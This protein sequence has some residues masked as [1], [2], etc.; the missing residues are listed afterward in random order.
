MARATYDDATKAAVM[1]NTITNIS[2]LRPD[3]SNA[4]K[5]TERGRYM[6]EA[7][8]REA[9]AGRSI[10]VDR[11][12]RIIAGNKTLDAWAEIGGEIEVVRTDGKRLVVVQR[13]DL[14]LADADS[15]A[16]RLAY[17][18]NR[19]G[20][21]GL[22]W[23]AEQILADVNAG[24]PLDDMFFKD[25]LDALLADVLPEPDPGEDPGP[26]VDRAEE[27]RQEWGVEPGQMW[28]L[29]EHRLICGDCTDPA[30]VE[31]VMGGEKAGAVVTDPPYGMNY[32]SDAGGKVANDRL[33]D[34]RRLLEGLPALFWST[35]AQRIAVWTRWDIWREI[36]DAFERLYPPCAMVV[37]S[38]ENHAQGNTNHFG[39]S[40]ELCYTSAPSNWVM[41]VDGIRPLNVVT[42]QVTGG[43]MD[44]GE[45]YH[46]TQKPIK[47]M[48]HLLQAMTA[49]A[50]N[51]FDPFS[52]SGTT[53]IACE[54]LGRK[55]R[56][57]EISPAYVAVALER[58]AVMTGKTPE[59]VS[60]A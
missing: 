5:G 30:V 4:N 45:R 23:D 22:S 32:I 50:E 18:D 1:G 6:I 59:L 41:K 7:S 40:H 14:D 53:L 35:G 16:R 2:D 42:E 21:V 31:R 15:P 17:L 10:V 27:L 54:Q 9:G 24:V 52:G 33:R 13:E 43:T 51:V 20:E 34:F 38:K 49:P 44:E 47:V 11:A 26:Q 46:L 37:W 28:Q 48:D 36:Q 3:P 56:A 55:C 60:N 29:G 39:Q 58:W 19:A 25:E 12:G 57:V 8:L